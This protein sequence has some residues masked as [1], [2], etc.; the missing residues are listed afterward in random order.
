[1]VQVARFSEAKGAIKLADQ[2]RRRG[3]HPR[4]I[5]VKASS[6]SAFFYVRI[7]PFLSYSKASDALRLWKLPN[8]TA[9][10]IPIDG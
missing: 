1:M 6:G 9:T 3:G 10:I 5:S 2:L 4:V 7:G 8:H